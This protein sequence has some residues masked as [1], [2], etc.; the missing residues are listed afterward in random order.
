MKDNCQ[1]SLF[2]NSATK[3]FQVGAKVADKASTIT[4]SDP[5]KVLEEAILAIDVLSER[6][7]FKLKDVDCFYLLL[8]PGSNTG[9]RLGLT[10]PRTIYALNPGIKLFG[11]PTLELFQLADKEGIPILSDRNGN[12][13]IKEGEETKRIEKSDIESLGTY[14]TYIIE[15][16]DEMAEEELKDRPLK[17]IDAL[18]VMMNNAD[19]FQDYSAEEEKFLP[20]YSQQI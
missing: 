7:G 16:A 10:I 11:L 14:S 13:F 20:V 15:S 2:I 1:V 9:I 6:L 4:L 19:K 5:K 12:L 18:N 17:K 8:G 3:T